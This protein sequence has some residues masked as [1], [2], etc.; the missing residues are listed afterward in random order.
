M[1]APRILIITGDLVDQDVDAIVNAANSDLVLGAGVAGAIRD[2]GGPEIQRECDEHGSVGIGEAAITCG[3]RAACA[4]RD[5]CREHG[6]G[7]KH[8]CAFAEVFYGPIVSVGARARCANNCPT[9]GWYRHCRFSNRGVR[10]GDGWFAARC[11][12]GRLATT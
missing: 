11:A 9:G 6:S 5:T 1:P 8:D 12:D 4:S 10:T 7:Q 3:G 2:R